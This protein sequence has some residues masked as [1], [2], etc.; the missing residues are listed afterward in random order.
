MGAAVVFLVYQCGCQILD[1]RSAVFSALIT[2]LIVPF[3]YYSKMTNLDVPY[4]F[5]FMLSLFFYIRI[6]K[7][8]KTMD[9]LFFS[10]TAALSICTKDQAFGLYALIPVIFI[11]AD[12]LKNR[13][14][15]G[16]RNLIH[17]IFSQ[18][19]ILSLLMFTCIFLVLHNVFFNF[20]GFVN[21]I[22]V[23]T[24]SGLKPYQMYQNNFSGDVDL[25]WLTLRQIQFS[26]QWPFLILC[27]SGVFI[28]MFRREKNMILFS[29]LWIALSY[30]LFYIYVI[31]YNYDRFNIPICILLAFFGGYCISVIL[32]KRNK[33]S[34][35]KVMVLA[36]IILYA[37]YNSFS[38]NLMMIKDSRY[39]IEKWMKKNIKQDTLI[40]VAG[41]IEYMPRMDNYSWFKIKP[42]QEDWAQYEKAEVLLFNTEYSLRFDQNSAVHQFFSKQNE[43][44]SGYR[45]EYQ[46][47][48]PFKWIFLKY[49]N[50]LTNIDKINPEIKIFKK[51]SA[52]N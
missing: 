2:S 7:N 35:L 26:I 18:N 31:R 5:W 11:F 36:L 42:F 33:Y 43:K 27:L 38:V 13:K 51:V 45:L 39:V 44:N 9:Y 6:L 40:G 49:E 8:H 37:V 14:E 1:R 16:H 52:S 50:V 4:I 24:G 25:L 20:Q 15:N 22:K 41:P 32:G 19:H 48:T 3:V 34:T 30:Y 46:Y 10:A 28:S 23:I 21:H 29:L 47:K 12:W 17:I